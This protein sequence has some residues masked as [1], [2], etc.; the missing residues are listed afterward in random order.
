[1]LLPK[2]LNLCEQRLNF[3]TDCQGLKNWFGKFMCSILAT[4]FFLDWR[5]WG[6]NSWI[7]QASWV[8]CVHFQALLTF[9]ADGSSYCFAGRTKQR[10]IF[11]HWKLV[12]SRALHEAHNDVIV[13]QVNTRK[14]T[15]FKAE[16]SWIWE[17]SAK[18][19]QICL[20]LNVVL[21]L[22]ITYL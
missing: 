16:R 9:S 12:V 17:H 6:K 11:G 5:L 3:W 1:M 4:T 13:V 8:I 21:F 20:E 2:H 10:T 7:S 15:D 18:E 22:R 14:P 19:R